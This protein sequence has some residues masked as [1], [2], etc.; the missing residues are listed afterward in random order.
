MQADQHTERYNLHVLLRPAR[1]RHRAPD[2]HVQLRLLFPVVLQIVLQMLAHRL[3]DIFKLGGLVQILTRLH[4]LV[5]EG[6]RFENIS[7]LSRALVL[8]HVE[9]VRQD[10]PLG[11][12]ALDLVEH[13]VALLLYLGVAL[14]HAAV[15]QAHANGTDLVDQ[16]LRDR[17]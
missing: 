16:R 5:H 13:L 10:D 14:H 6:H 7:E 8:V 15:D 4:E 3:R 17:V 1:L 9:E 2:H 12:D 11:E